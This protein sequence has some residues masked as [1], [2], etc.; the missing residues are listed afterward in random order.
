MRRPHAYPHDED[1]DSHLM[2]EWFTWIVAPMINFFFWFYMARSRAAVEACSAGSS[3]LVFRET[4]GQADDVR[5]GAAPGLEPCPGDPL[6][7]RPNRAAAHISASSPSSG[8]IVKRCRTP[9]PAFPATHLESMP[10]IDF[11]Q[12]RAERMGSMNYPYDA[13]TIII[14]VRPASGS[15]ARRDQQTTR[16]AHTATLHKTQS[17]HHPSHPSRPSHP[18][19]SA[20]RSHTRTPSAHPSTTSGPAR[21]PPLA[22]QWRA[23]ATLPQPS[24]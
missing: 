16:T 21:N 23:W 18:S 19:P 22:S 13:E 24:P 3:S 8:R 10:S 5:P 20:P 4:F 14:K 15:P 9:Y 7:T 1:D 12:Y 2:R 6:S 11:D 17:T